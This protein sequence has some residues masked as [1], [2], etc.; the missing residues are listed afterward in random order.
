[1]RPLDEDDA[2]NAPPRSPG[3]EHA[4]C[5]GGLGR[6]QA[7]TLGRLTIALMSTAA[8]ALVASGSL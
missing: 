2:G 4:K 5:P 1:M 7:R 6:G 3:G 8:L